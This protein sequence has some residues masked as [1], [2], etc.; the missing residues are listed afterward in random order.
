LRKG[1]ADIK[2]DCTLTLTKPKGLNPYPVKTETIMNPV[3]LIGV[4]SACALLLPVTIIL[5][6]R[7]YGNKSLICLLVY[8]FI[9]AF[10][11]L[12]VEGIIPAANT[13]ID[14]VGIVNNYL[15]IPLMLV[16]FLFFSNNKGK[17]KV[18]YW[19]MG[20][21]VSFELILSLVLG[22][23][24]TTAIY[25]TG[26]GIVLMMVYS[27]YLFSQYVKLTIEKN[28]AWGR[29]LMVTSILF[30]YCCYAMIYFI[31]YIQKTSAVADVFIIY[32]IVSIISS[33]LMSIGLLWVYNRSKQ[34]KEV[35]LTRKE[36]ALFF[37]H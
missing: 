5:T 7:L 3:T 37:N 9:T 35:Q 22:F 1:Y 34:I 16:I 30:A 11:N 29:T 25:I 13:T 36:L 17:Q 15:D 24:F 32:Y 33:I 6:C 28:K 18:I 10:Y 27:M 21:F 23:N 12:M 2:M 31:Y 19:S 20:I 8:Y 4:I 14:L 26:T